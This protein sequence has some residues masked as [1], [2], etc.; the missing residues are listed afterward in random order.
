MRVIA[1]HLQACEGHLDQKGLLPVDQG[2]KRSDRIVEGEG[3]VDVSDDNRDP[4]PSERVD[5]QS[6]LILQVSDHTY[7]TL[8]A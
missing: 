4:N 8:L 2:Q 6:Y 3:K 5:V 1:R 7:L